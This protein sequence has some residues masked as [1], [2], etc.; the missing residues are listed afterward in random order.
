MREREVVR[1]VTPSIRAV[2]Q[3]DLDDTLPE[4]GVSVKTGGEA[5]DYGVKG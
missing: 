3:L 2:A 4:P 1:A 5:V